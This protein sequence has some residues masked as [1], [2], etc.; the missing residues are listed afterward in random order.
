MQIK[1]S[2]RANMPARG[3]PGLFPVNS[4]CFTPVTGTR[5]NVRVLV[6]GCSR[7]LIGISRETLTT[8]RVAKTRH[9]IS[10]DLRRLNGGAQ[11]IPLAFR[12]TC[13]SDRHAETT[14]TWSWRSSSFQEVQWRKASL[15]ICLWTLLSSIFLIQRFITSRQLFG[16]GMNIREAK[17][18]SLTVG[19]TKTDFF[20]FPVPL[21]SICPRR[22]G[23]ARFLHVQ[24]PKLRTP[25]LAANR[26]KAISL[27]SGDH[28]AEPRARSP[29]SLAGAAGPGRFAGTRY[30]L[31]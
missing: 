1:S 22:L 27:P 26:N 15:A 18:D 3:Q 17:S 28:R 21:R 10:G 2:V 29:L 5:E 14:K 16:F 30:Y 12:S 25:S 19:W 7:P 4:F 11:K 8:H 24:G 6:D 20:F 13:C 23:I 9:E 31:A